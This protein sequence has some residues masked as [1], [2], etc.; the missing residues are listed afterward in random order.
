MVS[1]NIPDWLAAIG[2]L[3]V[4][5]AGGVGVYGASVS[6]V[7]TLSTV[8]GYNQTVTTSNAD[9]IESLTADVALVNTQVSVMSESIAGV[10]QTQTALNG[11]VLK[12]LNAVERLNI[13][14][15]KLEE[16]I[17]NAKER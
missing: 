11:S 3:V 8:V 9:K 12:L 17:G 1:R 13:S 2:G 6:E 10:Q 15:A 14:V 5:V 7:A 4:L 16:R